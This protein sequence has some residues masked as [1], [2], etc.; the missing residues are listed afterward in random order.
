MVMVPDAML[1]AFEALGWIPPGS[2]RRC[3]EQTPPARREPAA[4]GE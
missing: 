2:A 4:V 3:R 1:D